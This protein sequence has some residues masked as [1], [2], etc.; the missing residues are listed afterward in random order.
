MNKK[1]VNRFAAIVALSCGLLLTTLL[2]FSAPSRSFEDI[3]S[4]K[5][6]MGFLF[7]IVGVWALRKQ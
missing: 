1:T 7:V 6:L 5:L 3:V 2:I 4:W